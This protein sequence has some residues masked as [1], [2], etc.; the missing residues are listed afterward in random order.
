MNEAMPA[1]RSFYTAAGCKEL[2]E[3]DEAILQV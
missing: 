2:I 3:N 1:S